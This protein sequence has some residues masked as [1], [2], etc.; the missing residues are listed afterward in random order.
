MRRLLTI[1]LAALVVV[2]G[3]ITPT[4]AGPPPTPS[5]AATPPAPIREAPNA[6]AVVPPNYLLNWS[7]GLT[8]GTL[9]GVTCHV[10]DPWYRLPAYESTRTYF[11]WYNSCGIVFAYLSCV[12]W[13]YNGGELGWTFSSRTETSATN[14]HVFVDTGWN[15][16]YAVHKGI[17]CP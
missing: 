4:S 8:V 12:D 14:A 5:H 11:G 2:F 1:G 10:G 7:S 6:T 3:F 15:W 13:W 16:R 9:P 17:H